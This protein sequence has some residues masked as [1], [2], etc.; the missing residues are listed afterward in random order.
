MDRIRRVVTGLREGRSVVVADHLVDPVRVGLYPDTDFFLLWGFNGVPAV[1]SGDGGPEF[2]PYFPAP[3][4]TRFVLLRWPADG[5]PEPVGTA[6]ELTEEME[7]RLPGA[8]GAIHGH[9]RGPHATDTVDWC[10]V[11]DGDMLMALDDG[12]VRLGAGD[13]VVQRGTL[14]SWRNPGRRPVLMLFALI[15]AHR[16]R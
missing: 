7:R 5:S 11:L 13:V 9:P 16:T 4:G 15:G 2:A 10:M 8:L 12:E 1:G 14:H 3:G 6:E